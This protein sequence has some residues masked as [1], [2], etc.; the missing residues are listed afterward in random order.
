MDQLQKEL[1]T[2]FP[3]LNIQLIGVNKVGK[4]AGNEVAS[5]GRDIPLLQD[6]DADSDGDSDVWSLWNVQWRDVVI[7]DT[8]NTNVGTY[9]LTTYGL[10]EPENYAS[11]REMLVDAA[12]QSQKPWQNPNNPFDVDNNAHVTLLDVLAI[13]NELNSAGSHELAP[14]TADSSPPPYYDCDG[15]GD[16]TV[17]DVLQVMN[18]LTAKWLQAAGE[19]ESTG[20][21][22]PLVGTEVRSTNLAQVWAAVRSWSSEIG[23]YGPAL[24]L[25]QSRDT[26]V[27]DADSHVDYI[28]RVFSE[29][30]ADRTSTQVRDMMRPLARNVWEHD[31]RCLPL[32]TGSRLLLKSLLPTPSTILTRANASP[33]RLND[34]D[35]VMNDSALFTLSLL[36]CAGL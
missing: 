7:M 32:Q 25:E 23:G 20:L 2:N 17:L 36:A 1:E 14:P 15:D 10:A 19:G 6:V 3:A 26:F 8:H 31:D 18:R 35:I 29:E 13:V 22:E 12:M 30:M 34:A 5:E 16:V 28:D 33:L 4:E 24:S 27:P 11:L 9:N 21:S